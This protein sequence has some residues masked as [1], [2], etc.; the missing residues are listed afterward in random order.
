MLVITMCVFVY[1]APALLLAST[2]RVWLVALATFAHGVCGQIVGVLW[3]TTLHRKIPAEMLSRVSAYDALGSFALAPLGLIA[4]GV[5]IEAL[6]TQITAWI[7][8][9]MVLIPTV[10]T[11]CVRDVRQMRLGA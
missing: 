1:A 10:L 3:Y 6:G 8:V 11:L 2:T 4:A 5:S 7:A 9:A